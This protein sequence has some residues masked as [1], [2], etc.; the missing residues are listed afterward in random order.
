MEERG[1]KEGYR[2]RLGKEGE[3]KALE[4]L[5]NK[6]FKL[7]EKNYRC[8][9]G[10]V[11]LI[12]QDKNTIVFVEVK[13]RTSETYG[14]PQEA[15]TLNK[16]RKMIKAALTFL[17]EKNMWDQSVR[18]DVVSVGSEKLTHFRGAFGGFKEYYF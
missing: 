7:I 2:Q 6:G 17:Q 3:T 14:L 15:V 1:K 10:E 4:F 16:K 12:C 8:R 5:E 13:N 9:E 11:D 18:F